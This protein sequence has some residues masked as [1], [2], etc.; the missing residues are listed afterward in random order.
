MLNHQQHNIIP[1][2]NQ[3]HESYFFIELVDENGNKFGFKWT[4]EKVLVEG[5]F[6]DCWM[7]TGV[8]QPMLL[9]KSA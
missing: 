3:M 2:E 6:K 8:S 9:A 4:V 1:V 7:T 5:E